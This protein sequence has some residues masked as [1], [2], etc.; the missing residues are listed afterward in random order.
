M[1]ASDNKNVVSL[2]RFLDQKE[3][4]AGVEYE[5]LEG[6]SKIVKGCGMSPNF[7]G[8][9]CL[10][11]NSIVITGSKGGFVGSLSALTSYPSSVRIMH[12]YNVNLRF[13]VKKSQMSIKHYSLCP[14]LDSPLD[15][16]QD[17]IYVENKGSCH[18]QT[19]RLRI[20]S[21][22]EVFDDGCEDTDLCDMTD[23]LVRALYVFAKFVFERLDMNSKVIINGLL[24]L[25]A[26]WTGS[27]KTLIHENSALI[28][29]AYRILY[30]FVNLPATVSDCAGF[31]LGAIEDE[32]FPFVDVE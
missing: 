21:D 12:D 9:S 28:A 20:A 4:A 14:I 30:P 1:I 22:L 26:Y 18:W 29:S 7:A 2:C 8:V 23:Y 24:T 17:I 3:L 10:D 31:A 5:L 15:A 11:L 27:F 32:L 6:D 13:R 19:C 25:L 16:F